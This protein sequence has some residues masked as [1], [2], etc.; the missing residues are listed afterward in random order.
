MKHGV[1]L[2]EALFDLARD[3]GPADIFQRGDGDSEFEL[4]GFVGLE[5]AAAVTAEDFELVR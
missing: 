4:Q 5:I 1:E 3:F 2:M